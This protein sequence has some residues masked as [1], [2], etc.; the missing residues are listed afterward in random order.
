MVLMPPTRSNSDSWMARRSLTC[1]ST[2]ISP[3][4]SRNRVPPSASSK[5]P[6]LEL[7]APV[8]APFS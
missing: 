7:V 8:N 4:S 1:I 2:G 5:R 6:G 3:I